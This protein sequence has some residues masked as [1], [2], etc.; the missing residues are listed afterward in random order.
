MITNQFEN[1]YIRFWFEDGLVFGDY[2]HGVTLDIE[3]AKKTAADR[4]RFCNGQDFPHVINITGV[5]NTSKEAR[6]YFSQGNGIKHMKCLA[7]IT[8]SPIS[9]T[10]LISKPKVDTKLFVNHKDAVEWSKSFVMTV[11]AH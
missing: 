4:V 3:A 9:R 6:D 8:D 2:K 11:G 7:L 10:I 5:K 1:E